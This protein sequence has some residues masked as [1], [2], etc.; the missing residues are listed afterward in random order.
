MSDLQQGD[1]SEASASV[2]RTSM[3]SQLFG[4]KPT[5]SDSDEVATAKNLLALEPFSY[6]ARIALGDAL[7]TQLRYIEAIDEYS[8]AIGLDAKNITG[9]FKRAQRYLSIHKFYQALADYSV[10]SMALPQRFDFTYRI[11]MLWY[12]LGEFE[13]SI[14]LFDQACD[15]SENGEML[16]AVVYWRYLAM[17]RSGKSGEG[18]LGDIEAGM[19]VGHHESYRTALGLFRNEYSYAQI[20]D[21]LKEQKSDID[22]VT[23]LYALYHVLEQR[24]EA[25]SSKRILKEAV[26]RNY[27]W[28]SFSYVAALNDYRSLA[29]ESSEQTEDN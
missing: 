22:Y 11:G 23:I 8:M 20:A 6:E 4:T 28:P 21:I 15:L 24:G 29:P 2:E 14:E 3:E 19:N 7:C 27:H 1:Y 9:Y 10:C 16:V 12:F 5:V 17:M 26:K 25:E 13:K 18:S